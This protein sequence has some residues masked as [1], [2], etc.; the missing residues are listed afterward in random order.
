MPIR[1]KC[2]C[3]NKFGA[4]S[5]YAGKKVKCPECS[6]PLVIPKANGSAKKAAGLPAKTDPSTALVPASGGK[7]KSKKIAAKSS[8]NKIAKSDKIAVKCKCGEKF[9]A[10][11]EL[12]GKTVRCPG[13]QNPVK[14]GG[15]RQVA[16]AKKKAAPAPSLTDDVFDELGIGSADGPERKC[17]E[18]KAVMSE[19]AILCIECGYNENLGRKMTVKRPVTQED[20]EKAYEE[21]TLTGGGDV[22]KKKSGLGNIF[23]A[24]RRKKK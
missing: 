23:G 24:F 11:P 19:E 5:K 9:A 12:K 17:P 3:G 1:V 15:S 2:K 14:I 20:R 18:C 7:S 4:P 22:T 10:K 13:C 21:K 16:V 8:K 6:N